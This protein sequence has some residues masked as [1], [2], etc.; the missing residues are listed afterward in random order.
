MFHLIHSYLSL[1][2]MKNKS[3]NSIL[4]TLETHASH[5]CFGQLEN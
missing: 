3:K 2:K 1:F 4:K 5:I